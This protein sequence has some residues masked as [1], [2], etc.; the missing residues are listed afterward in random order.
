MME[1]SLFP[2]A[3]HPLIQPLLKY[4]DWELL[5]LLQ[6]HPDEGKYFLAI[7]CRYSELTYTLIGSSVSSEIVANY[8]FGLVWREI[9]NQLST[10]E[11]DSERESGG[12]S[13][14]NWLIELTSLIINE[15]ESISVESI[16][17]DLPTTSLPLKFY[18]EQALDGLL[19]LKFYLERALD[20]L[21]PLNRL[22]VLVSEK[23]AWNKEKIVTY[24]QQQGEIVSD[25]DV[26]IYLQEGYQIL[27]TNL[28][29]DIR[30]IYL[31]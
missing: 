18:L 27:T 23:F 12:Q 28:P 26:E 2:E 5:H 30:S 14:L 20:R 6:H 7:F 13:L 29:S 9:F 31:P 22:I 4:E 24:L 1:I 11:L 10:L 16:N 19:P 21:P 25:S 3:N 15:F 8:L 17:D